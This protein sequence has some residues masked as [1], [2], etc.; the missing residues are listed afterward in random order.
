M[1]RPKLIYFKD[2]IYDRLIEESNASGLINTLLKNYYKDMD[3]EDMTEEEIRQELEIIKIKEE[4]EE[5]IK[6]VRRKQKK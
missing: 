1:G 6:N 5:K 2:A 4:T 3:M